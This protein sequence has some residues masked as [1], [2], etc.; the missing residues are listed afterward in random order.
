VAAEIN[1]AAFEQIGV[2]PPT[3]ETWSQAQAFANLNDA[4]LARY[5]IYAVVIGINVD[6]GKHVVIVAVSAN[7]SRLFPSVVPIVTVT[8]IGSA[9]IQ[10]FTNP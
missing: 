3:G 10:A 4:V 2:L 8:E 5:G 7:L 6:Q 9:N 1:Q